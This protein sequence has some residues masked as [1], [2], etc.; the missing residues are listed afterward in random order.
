MSPLE[1]KMGFWTVVLAVIT[2][3]FILEIIAAFLKG[4][5]KGLDN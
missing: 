5:A 1:V 3:K 2:A 4:V